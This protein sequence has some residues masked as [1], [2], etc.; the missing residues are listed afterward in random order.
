MT[1]ARFAEEME[2]QAK[3]LRNMA[4]AEATMRRQ[5][6][7]LPGWYA[8]A[9]GLQSGPFESEDAAREAMR[10]SPK[11]RAEQTREHGSDYPFPIDLRIWE[12]KAPSTTKSSGSHGK[13]EKAQ[14][15]STR[16]ARSKQKTNRA[17][18]KSDADVPSARESTTS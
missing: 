6:C 10:L 7:L 14:S 13:K 8:Y 11:A 3:R 9:L 17:A 5:A 12:E 18:Q 1:W 15:P 2:R 4:E 16:K